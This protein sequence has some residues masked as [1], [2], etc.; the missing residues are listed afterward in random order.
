MNRPS[1]TL[2]TCLALVLVLAAAAVAAPPLDLSVTRNGIEP[3]LSGTN[4]FDWAV[5]W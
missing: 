2:P 5:E 3:V 1:A 4:G